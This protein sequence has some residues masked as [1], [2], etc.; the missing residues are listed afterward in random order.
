MLQRQQPSPVQSIDGVAEAIGPSEAFQCILDFFQRQYRVIGITAAIFVAMG[1][2][3]VVT[4]PPRY[5]AT[6]TMLIDTQD[7]HLFQ[8]QSMFSD[9]PVAIDTGTVE[10]QVEILKSENIALTV[11]KNLNLTKDPEFIGPSGGLVSA[12]LGAVDSLF[13]GSA[14]ASE[15]ALSRRAVKVFHSRLDV[16]RVGL[17]YVITISFQSENPD[18]AAQIA[19]AVSNAYIDDQLNA[20]YQAARRAGTWLQDRLRELREQAATAEGAVVAFKNKNNIVEAAG[21]SMNDQELAELNSELVLARSQTAEAGAKVARVQAVLN[22]N[23]PEAAIDATVAD[24]L[25]DDVI[26]KLRS[27]YLELSAREEDWAARYGYTHLAV[28]NLRNQM[29]E[30]QSSIRNELQRIAHSYNSDL[31]ISEQHEASVQKQLDQAVSQSQVNNQSEIALRELESQA[32]TYRALYDNFLQRYMESVQQQS[33]P[34]TNARV[35]SAATRPL[36]PSHPRTL[37]VLAL[38]GMAGLGFGVG[39]G[40]WREFADRVF[41]TS[42]QVESLLETDCIALVP[43]VKEA[44]QKANVP[45]LG[46]QQTGRSAAV[47]AVKDAI[48][49]ANIPGLRGETQIVK[50]VKSPD[51]GQQRIVVTSG[52]LSTIV[53]SPFSAFAEA[54]RSIKVAIDQSP[55]GTGGRIIGFTSSVPNEGKSSVAC[56]V[57]RLAA[58]TGS[59][60]LLIDCDIRNPSLSRTLSP[61]AAGGLL[62]VLGGKSTLEQ[63]IWLDSA[64]N[65]RFLPVATKARVAHS[66]EIIASA[67]IRSIFDTL[68]AGYDYIIV[69]FA[70]LMPIVDVRASMHLV[71]SYVYVVEWGRT[72]IEH[73][74][75]ALQSARGVYEHLLGAV[76]NKVDLTSLGQYD[77]RGGGYYRDESYRRYGYTD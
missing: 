39:A 3:Y 8:Q 44:A 37:L 18:R 4:T 10:S 61:G 24:S 56:A 14:P 76:L 40:A 13:A 77:G 41:R 42:D 35:I 60:T 50:N 55:T 27:Q 70:P 62:D 52:I 34:I 66:S 63:A 19:N 21:R 48:Q 17:T 51:A 12:I 9:M 46:R 2:I 74:E 57:A 6:A 15:F 16:Q 28:V 29:A 11:I 71:D 25:K 68:R 59:R 22:S 45:G 73:V 47:P 49:K 36:S 75:H 58:Q 67:Q 31:N 20:K 1:S 53:E 30:I 32:Q 54:I 23:T 38:A 64:T 69:D 72:R 43:A 26:Q 5:T 7:A 33:F 65:M